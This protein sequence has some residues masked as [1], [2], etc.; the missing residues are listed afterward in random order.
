MKRARGDS[1]CRGHVAFLR[2]CIP[3]LRGADENA[4]THV[5]FHENGEQVAK[6]YHHAR[7][8]KEQARK[9][10]Q[11]EKQQRRSNRV[12]P[13]GEDEAVGAVPGDVPA[14][15]GNPTSGSGP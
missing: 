15:P 9:A 1:A 5:Q 10:R 12:G 8:Q 4:I 13:G 2:H 3:P 7:K 6:N 11:Q 14:A